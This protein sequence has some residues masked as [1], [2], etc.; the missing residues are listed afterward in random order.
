MQT[1]DVPFIVC[2]S[3]YATIYSGVTEDG[4]EVVGDL[5]FKRRAGFFGGR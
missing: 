5:P 4:F 3:L 2:A 1:R